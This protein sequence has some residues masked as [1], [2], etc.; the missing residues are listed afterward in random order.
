M[1]SFTIPTRMVKIMKNPS[2][3]AI[4]GE[5]INFLEPVTLRQKA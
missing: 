4:V 5:K 2:G 3:N 1:G